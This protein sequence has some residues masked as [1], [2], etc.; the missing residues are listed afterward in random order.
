MLNMHTD[1]ASLSV[2]FDLL[3]FSLS[4]FEQLFNL[5]LSLELWLQRARLKYWAVLVIKL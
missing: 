1:L 2:K 3:D 4:I 5:H